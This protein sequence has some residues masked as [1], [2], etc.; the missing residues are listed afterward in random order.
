LGE[1]D[2]AALELHSGAKLPFH[3]AGSGASILYL[4]HGLNAHSGTWRKNISALAINRKVVA[5]SL[6]PWPPS[7]PPE[8]GDYTR[9]II[10]MIQKQGPEKLALAGNSMGGWI[11]MKIAKRLAPLVKAVVLE[12]SAGT[13]DPLD[14]D[15]IDN[16]DL[17]AIPTLIIWGRNDRIIP[18]SDADF[19]HS[20]IR[21][22]VLHIF[23]A[24]HVPHWEK[25]EEYNKLVEDFLRLHIL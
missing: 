14:L 24:G 19:L 2:N 1:Y 18:V 22:S 12:D 3:E 17:L 6:P 25:T 5:P 9:Q 8:I 11:A 10:E 16:L 20:K 4:L 7:R 21:S 23:E 13:R 15:A